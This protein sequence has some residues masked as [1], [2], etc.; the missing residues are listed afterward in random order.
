MDSFNYVITSKGNIIVA[1]QE[2]VSSGIYTFA[3]TL[4]A[5]M[6]PSATIVVYH[7]GRFGDVLADSITFPVNGISRNNVSRSYC[8]MNLVLLSSTKNYG[9][10][11]MTFSSLYSSTI[12][13]LEQVR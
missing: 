6:S 13:K 5:E 8:R 3:V 10:F 11:H 1:G 2:G 4:S 7:V 12:V 9:M